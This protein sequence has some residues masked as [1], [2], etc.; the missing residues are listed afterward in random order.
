MRCVSNSKIVVVIILIII[1][2]PCLSAVIAL[3]SLNSC[4]SAKPISPKA[5][6]VRTTR[7]YQGD[8]CNVRVVRQVEAHPDAW[9]LWQPVIAQWN[10]K[11]LR[12]ELN[13]IKKAIGLYR[14]GGETGQDITI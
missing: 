11:H 10:R 9:R 12:N 13:A 3:I 14:A 2:S 6:S 5:P 7:N 1:A 4:L 8:V